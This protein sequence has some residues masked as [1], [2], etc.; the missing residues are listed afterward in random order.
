MKQI[1]VVRIIGMVCAL[2]IITPYLLSAQGT[3]EIHYT[4]DVSQFDIHYDVVNE[5]DVIYMKKASV[6]SELGKPVLPVKSVGIAL[7]A[8]TEAAAVV[9][10]SLSSVEIPGDFYIMPGQPPQRIGTQDGQ[11]SVEPDDA[12]YN[13]SKPFPGKLAALD[14]QGN[15]AGQQIV[16]VTVYPVHYVPAQRQLLLH[17]HIEVVVQCV[18]ISDN[19]TERGYSA[20]TEHQRKL[21]EDMIKAIV[22]NPGDVRV[23]LGM[24]GR[25][26]FLPPGE[27]SHVIITS[28]ALASYFEPLASW[29]TLKGLRDTVVTTEWI[30]ANYS[31]PGDSLR[32]RQFVM[33]A[34]TT[35]GTTYV[36]MGGEGSI[37]PWARR[38]Y[39]EICP[40]DQYYSDWNDDWF[41]EVRVGRA[42]VDNE[43][44]ATLFINKVLKYEK[45]PSLTDYPLEVLLI[46]MDLDAVTPCEN[47][48][49]AIASYI[50]GHFN[51][52]K[53]YDS[54]GGNHRDSALVFLNAGM[55]LVNHADHSNVTVMATGDFHHGWYID[56]SDVDNLTNNDKPSIIV[57]NGC[58]ANAMQ[59]EDCISEHFVVYNDNQAGV[60]F[61]GNTTDGIYYVGNPFSLTNEL[62]NWLWWGMFGQNQNDLGKA[63]IYSKHQFY[64][65]SNTNRHCE[66]TLS[67]LGE[68]AMPI[69][70][71][72]PDSMVVTYDPFVPA[73]S[74]TFTVTVMG[75]DGATPV[76]DALVCC[77][78]PDQT[79]ELYVTGYTGGSGQAML[80]I[81]PTTPGDTMLVTVTANNHLY[82]TG[83]AVITVTSGPF[84]LHGSLLIDGAGNGEAN[85]GE[86]VDFG[87]WAKNIGV[88]TAY[89]VYGLL[90]T[91]DS[92]VTSI[93]ADSSWFG[94]IAPDGDT[95]LSNPYY[96]FS[97]ADDCPD[98]HVIE[99]ALEFH[100]NNGSTW[101]SNPKVTVC[102]PFLTYQDASVVG[103]DWD[104]GMLDPN[105]TADLVVTL[106]NEGAGTAEDVTSTLIAVT[107]GIHIAKASGDYGTINP[108]ASADNAGDPYI[109]KAAKTVPFGTTVNLAVVVASGV[110]VD[111]VGFS[112]VVGQSVPTDT[113]YY[114]AYYSGGPY[115]Q[116]PV[117]SWYAIDST[118]TVNPGVSLDLDRNE[119]VVVGLPFTFQ[120]YGV[121][122]DRISISS[123]G[124]IAMDSTGSTDF[125]NSGI[126]FGDG[127]A[128]MVAGLWDYL[129]PANIGGPGDVY[130]Y[131]D[132]DNHRFVVEYFRIEHYPT[133]GAYETFEIILYDPAYH[134]SP[135]GDG[136]IVVQYYDELQ[137]PGSLTIGIENTDQT[138]GVQYYFNGVYD[139]LAFPV[140]DGFAVKFRAEAP[141]PGIEEY[142]DAFAV[143]SRTLLRGFAPNPFAV[144][145]KIVYQL[146]E[147]SRVSLRVYDAAG[148]L[149]RNLAEGKS[150]P[151]YYTVLWDG[152]DDAGRKVSA[153]V[154]FVKFATDQYQKVTKAVLLR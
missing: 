103:G 141:I 17:T 142:G 119:T 31:G 79:P 81:S 133:G 109:V 101:T 4:V 9:A 53:V 138:V 25:S 154:Y 5:Y 135:T 149:V 28:G 35:W 114:Y 7:P 145:A 115:E 131:Y 45:D 111:T 18:P 42:S 94:D 37:V 11:I 124:W 34:C 36:L 112:L 110:Y 87:V 22:V 16:W 10:R 113:G 84:I 48:K 126:P 104:N 117:Y 40:S 20:V 62:D 68:P 98:G 50:P 6:L 78:I 52:H 96:N 19:S 24:G 64:H 57:S 41:H 129:Q 2:V 54:H 95:S 73:T 148:R 70:T 27:Y 100:D 56:M 108:G 26:L 147:V 85:P 93:T 38:N 123:N 121:D 152:R 66:W 139:S 29:H 32:V 76:S 33:D 77:W 46:G 8:G 39:T 1:G 99:F 59:A 23:N 137:V 153:G 120:Y 90:S 122:Y 143:P 15:V 3:S 14:H 83:Y 47:L 116:S 97:I 80:S 82:Y 134:T 58:F 144:R 75:S 130:Y 63:L 132:A 72:V 151:G 127:P 128:A 150:N 60:A 89:A 136:D 105:E 51:I 43:T 69:W 92:V 107:G 71:D 67:L 30:Y 49:E 146:A 86:D 140:T 61:I 88:D 65:G 12:V 21:Y 74:H 44:Q 125:S 55:N 91:S 106:K 118:Q 102:A 13:S